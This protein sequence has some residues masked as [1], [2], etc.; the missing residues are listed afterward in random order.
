VKAIHLA[1]MDRGGAFIAARR[2]HE[3]LRRV[4]VNSSIIVAQ[5]GSGAAD[6]E[7]IEFTDRSLLGRLRRRVDA[8]RYA[9]EQSAYAKAAPARNAHI[10]DDRVPGAYVLNKTLPQA[11]IYHLHWVNGFVDPRHFFA[12]LPAAT[13]LVWTLHDMNPFTG[14][15]HYSFD[16]SRYTRTCGSCPQLG[17]LATAD[18]SARSHAR[19]ASAYLTL[20][21]TTTRL[22]TPSKWLGIETARS[23]LMG[24]FGIEVIPNGI[25]TDVFAPRSGAAAREVFSIP[26]DDFVVV[27]AADRVGLYLKGLDLLREALAQLNVGRPVTLATIGDDG[28]VSDAS[29]RTVGL[30]RID[31]ERIM[32]FALS[33]ADLFVLPTRSDNLPNV[34]LEAMACGIPVVSFAVG[35]IPDMVRNGRTGLLAPPENVTALRGAIETILS[36][37]ELRLRMSSESRK[38]AVKEYAL[39]V[40]ARRHKILYE[41]L[42]EASERVRRDGVGGLERQ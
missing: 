31:N 5:K 9:R 36:D 30:G 19:K 1:T 38:I 22:V 4:A 14:G 27:F 32:S 23:S 13:P 7:A 17:S 29:R 12:G 34:I 21:P 25:D 37:D 8:A 42:I 18:L 10:T 24:R 11:D 39:E 33:V 15:C 35:G 40:P 16:C 3:G 26:A 6:V 41:K 28:E 2:L 20:S